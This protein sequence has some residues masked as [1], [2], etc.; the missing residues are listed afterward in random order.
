MEKRITAEEVKDIFMPYL[1][2]GTSLREDMNQLGDPEF[3]LDTPEARDLILSLLMKFWFAYCQGIAHRQPNIDEPISAEK[4]GDAYVYFLQT[5]QALGEI[6]EYY[7]MAMLA[8]FPM[9]ADIF[10]EII[11]QSVDVSKIGDYAVGIDAG[12]GSGVLLLAQHILALR[13]Q[14]QEKIE[15][16]GIEMNAK[17]ADRAH[18]LVRSL[19][20][21]EVRQGDLEKEKTLA[22]FRD[23]VIFCLT[24]ENL[25]H[26]GDYMSA[27]PAYR[28]TEAQVGT[29]DQAPL[30]TFPASIESYVQ[31]GQQEERI[32]SI[33]LG[34]DLRRLSQVGEGFMDLF[35]ATKTGDKRKIFPH[36]WKQGKNLSAAAE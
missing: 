22:E 35:L 11:R 36:R 13:H 14:V 34:G 23:K 2:E 19:F 31:P 20:G 8:D 1:K 17:T 5:I 26:E 3:D 15:L 9:T 33:E 29:F 6:N 4:F 27:E 21:G 25:P 12:S 28:A 16:I 32:R 18:E 24:N 10:L 30:Y 7:A